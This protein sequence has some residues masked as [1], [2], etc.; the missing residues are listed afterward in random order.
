MAGSTRTQGSSSR[1]ST[2]APADSAACL[3][4]VAARLAEEGNR[5]M[6]EL[7]ATM[8]ACAPASRTSRTTAATTFGLV[9]EGGGR[10]LTTFGLTRTRLPRR[11]SR[12]MPPIR[13]SPACSMACGSFPRTMATRAFPS[14]KKGLVGNGFAGTRTPSGSNSS[15]LSIDRGAKAKAGRKVS[16]PASRPSISRR[17]NKSSA[18][19][20]TR[21]GRKTQRILQSLG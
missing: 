14:L 12:P 8:T 19:L 5:M 7:S 13:L 16:P 6:P 18:P 2:D 11:S 1:A 4:P 21:H 9:V 3:M 10:S 17:V 15:V 20:T